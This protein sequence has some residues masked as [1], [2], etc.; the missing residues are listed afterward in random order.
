[1]DNAFHLAI[2]HNHGA[3]DWGEGEG[4]RSS[5]KLDGTEPLNSPEA[6]PLEALRQEMEALRRSHQLLRAEVADLRG[7]FGGLTPKSSTLGR[8]ALLTAFA[9]AAGGMVLAQ[10]A[11]AP[12]ADGDFVKAGMRTRASRSTAV[13]TSAEIGLEGT[14]TGAAG[15]GVFGQATAASGETFGV[16][17][18]VSSTA[19]KAL[20]GL[21][22]ATAGTT[23]GVYGGTTSPEGF[24]VF[25]SGRF[26]ATGRSFL[27]TP[28]STPS[29][30][31]L[32]NESIS[33]FLDQRANLLRVRVKYGDG[34]IRN[35]SIA[36]F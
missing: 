14:S 24:G 11:P 4:T 36:L 5:S 20:Y 29:N 6:S 32:D 10:I 31:D 30:A 17:G 22:A 35:G 15:T 19:G 21:A 7:R 8:R 25:S 23:Y 13:E 1:M 33:F 2:L 18:R 12:A 34:S 16:F 26:K 28:N 3:R 27:K 9:G